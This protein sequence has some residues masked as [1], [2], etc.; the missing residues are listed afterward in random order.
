MRGQS[1]NLNALRGANGKLSITAKPGAR[2]ETPEAA[3]AAKQ[4]SKDFWAQNERFNKVIDE[5]KANRGDMAAQLRLNTRSTAD[6]A[7]NTAEQQAASHRYTADQTLAGHKLTT[8]SGERVEN[9]RNEIAQKNLE[10]T[11]AI[12]ARG[13]A[14]N[15]NTEFLKEVRAAAPQK[16]K[17]GTVPGMDYGTEDDKDAQQ[18]AQDFAVSMAESGAIVP[19]DTS[20]GSASKNAKITM[21]AHKVSEAVNR[22]A[23]KTK[24]GVVGNSASDIR[25]FKPG[26]YG[27]PNFVNIAFGRNSVD[28]WDAI[29]AK[30]PSYTSERRLIAINR[31]T[32]QQ[33]NWQF[34]PYA[35]VLGEDTQDSEMAKSIERTQQHFVN[36]QKAYA[37]AKTGEK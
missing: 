30:M 24:I 7:R 17:A 31:G 8:E 4:A 6:T 32:E 36:R 34:A 1:E 10:A 5:G 11:R 9:T 25:V 22:Y 14:D 15:A 35:E 13:W 26:E 20:I 16:K 2:G 33:P 29:K 12:T 19:S 28:G 3:A 23:A 21:N 27:A 18:R 37:K